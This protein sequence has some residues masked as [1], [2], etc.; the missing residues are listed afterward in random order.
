MASKT[1]EVPLDIY[2]MMSHITHDAF[3]DLRKI[4]IEKAL[5]D[6]KASMEEFDRMEQWDFWES[7]MYERGLLRE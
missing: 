4:I 5:W 3:D 1:I 2:M 6:D 7:C